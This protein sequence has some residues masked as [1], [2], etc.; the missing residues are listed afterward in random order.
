MLW[1]YG[2]AAIVV[3]S[4]LLYMA[5]GFL[6]AGL[7]RLS[8]HFKVT[9]FVVAFFVMAFATSLPNLFVG[10]TSALQGIPELSFG[11][12]MGNNILVMTVAVALSVFFAPRRELPVETETTLDTTF[13]TAAAAIL[14]LILISDGLISRSDGLVLIL[15]FIGYAYWLFLRRGRFS[16]TVTDETDTLSREAVLLDMVKVI[17]GVA[18]LTLSAQGV[19]YGASL[20]G[21]AIDMPLVLIGILVTSLGGAL[22]EIYFSIISAR[23]GEIGLI[24]GGLLGAVIIPATLVLGLV[25][26]IH[27]IQNDILAFPVI[28][29]LFL[30]AIALFFLYVSQ[31]RSAIAWREAGILL[32]FYILFLLSLFLL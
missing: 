32:G 14:P 16:R 1:F 5:G 25:A 30:V 13:L 19:V 2:L 10:V 15:L 20:L 4:A 9:E 8:R 24:V 29:R 6:V 18:L 11:D 27:P 17:A 26:I 31:A 12:I 28:N 7:L 23:R 21:T 22:P 3:S